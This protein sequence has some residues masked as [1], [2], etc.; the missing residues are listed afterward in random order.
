M[1]SYINGK[2][3]TL[4]PTSLLI[5]NQGIGYQIQISLQTY[6]ALK[7]RTETSIHTFCVIK[8]ENQSNSIFATYGFATEQERQLFLQLVSVSGVGHNT[9][10]LILSS[11]E[12][13]YL[14]RVIAS[15]D[16]ATIMK[17][18]GIGG[19]TA[20]RIIIDLKDKIGKGLPEASLS[21]IATGNNVND[22]ALSALV[23]LGF[24]RAAAEKALMKSN[25]D[26]GADAKVEDLI[27]SA[28]GHLSS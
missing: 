22:E 14:V 19:K 17:V 9:A 21:G 28:L 4:T 15:G 5:E 3:K 24:N 6:T 27:K 7:D 25:K 12:P 8:A 11:F 2:V 16:A 23:T 1:Y 10:Q 18:K 13:D 20:Q 26:L